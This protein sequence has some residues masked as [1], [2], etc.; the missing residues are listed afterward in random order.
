M[1]YIERGQALYTQLANTLR[2]Q[3]TSGALPPGSPLPS[4]AQMKTT[5]GVSRPTARAAINALR[6]EGIVTVLHGKGSFVRHAPAL[7]PHTHP[8]AVTRTPTP[9]PPRRRR[10]TGAAPAAAQWRYTDSD[11]EALTVVGE[12]GHY[13]ITATAALALAL[14][15][16]EH[17]PLF[18][19]D[20]VL[21]DQTGQRM[22]HRLYLPIPICA[23]VPALESDPFRTPGELYTL[24]GA[25]YGELRFTEHVRARMPTPDDITTLRLPEATPLLH[26]QRTTHT[27]GG[28]PLALE[29]T[30]LCADNTQ[31]A[32]TLTPDGSE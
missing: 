32:Y 10:T 1:A 11:T 20:R 21:Q 5:Y 13:R 12:P 14:V 18:T 22:T 16:P 30:H 25:H 26:T 2:E 6:A 7:A 3:I 9:I 24:L 19:Y 23:E 28:R 8:R 27:P 4:E 29:E 31:L 15:V 17:T